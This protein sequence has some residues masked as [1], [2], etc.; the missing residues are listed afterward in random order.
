MALRLALDSGAD[1]IHYADMDRLIRW[2]ETRP[3]EW[4]RTVQF[5]SDADHAMMG[6]TAQAYRTHPNALI[7]TEKISNSFVSYCLGQPVDVSAGS[8][9]FS[10]RAAQ[11]LMANAKPGR[12]LG[13][14]GEWAVLLDRAGFRLCYVEV[15]GLDW[16][17]ADRYQDRAADGDRQRQMADAYDQDA[18]NWA[19]RVQV[20]LEIVQAG[21]DAMQR[22]LI[23]V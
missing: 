7:E 13:A 6:R 14:D 17:T 11:F 15:D 9:G 12:A 8:K 4:R 21:I 10:R 16:E 3:D 19:A 22:P 1:F 18:S 20:A 2:V 23:E 5:V